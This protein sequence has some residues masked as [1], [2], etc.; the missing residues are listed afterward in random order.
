MDILKVIESY[1]EK[2]GMYIF[3]FNK[4][5]IQTKIIVIENLLKKWF[6]FYM[7]VRK[8]KLLRVGFVRLDSAQAES[9]IFP[10]RSRI[11]PQYMLGAG[12]VQ[13]RHL[14]L[15]CLFA[16]L[17]SCVLFMNDNKGNF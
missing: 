15:N 3:F 6:I 4:G 9:P 5:Y 16:D 17:I 14:A 13:A 2:S 7:I 10:A 12:F 1:N 8:T 11:C